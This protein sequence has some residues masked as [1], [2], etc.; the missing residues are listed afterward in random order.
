MGTQLW[1]YRCIP[2]MKLSHVGHLRLA[3]HQPVSNQLTAML[4]HCIWSV[5]TR[6][7]SLTF[8]Y[9]IF[10]VQQTVFLHIKG[11]NP[12]KKKHH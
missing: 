11:P 1:A 5:M 7:H 12:V 2:P 6:K 9:Q 8:E 3:L 4:P 10:K